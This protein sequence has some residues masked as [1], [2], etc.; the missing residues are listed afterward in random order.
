MAAKS[1]YERLAQVD[2]FDED[3]PALALSRS[4]LSKSVNILSQPTHIH[5][6]P[7]STIVP[8]GSLASGIKGRHRS[9]SGIDIKAI[10][11]RLERYLPKLF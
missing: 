7:A 1:G 4:T 6:L 3:M 9:N 8:E 10:N 11:A 2:E 5:R